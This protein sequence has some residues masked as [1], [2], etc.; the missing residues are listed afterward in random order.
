MSRGRIKPGIVPSLIGIMVGV[1]FVILGL[2]V[3]IPVTNAA[4]FPASIFAIIWTVIAA[5]STL[6]YG[7]NLFRRGGVSSYDIDIETTPAD[8]SAEPDF[9]Q[10]LRKLA[11][12]KQDGLMSTEEFLAKRAELMRQRW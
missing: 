5:T 11:E 9:D 10:R 6:Y 7:I 12:L 1:L 4:G 3:F 2:A 8:A